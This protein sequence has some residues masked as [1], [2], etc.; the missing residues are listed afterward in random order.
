MDMELCHANVFIN[1]LTLDIDIQANVVRS[2]FPP[3]DHPHPN[4]HYRSM[5]PMPVGFYDLF[6]TEISNQIYN[7]K[8]VIKTCRH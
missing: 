4:L 3:F 8:Q 2:I 1:P 6:S 7:Q 5:Y